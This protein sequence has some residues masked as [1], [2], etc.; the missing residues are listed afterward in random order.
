MECYVSV[1]GAQAANLAL[2]VG[3]RGGVYVVG[4]IAP[5]ISAALRSGGLMA[6]FFDNPAMAD[7]LNR[8][9]V[10]IVLDSDVTLLGARGAALRR[11]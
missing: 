5:K 4:G 11:V 6:T 10:T 8:V 1:H 9:P 3:A 7:L 2:I